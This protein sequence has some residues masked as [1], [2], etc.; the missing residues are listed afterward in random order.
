ML[1][2]IKAIPSNNPSRFFNPEDKALRGFTGCFLT[3]NLFP[4]FPLFSAPVVAAFA[5]RCIAPSVVVYWLSPRFLLYFPLFPAAAVRRFSSFSL[6]SPSF[7]SPLRL[8]R[9]F[10]ILL[11][12]FQYPALFFHV[13]PSFPHRLLLPSL[14][15]ALPLPS[16]YIGCH[17][18]FFFI[19]LCSPPRLS[20]CG[21]SVFFH[22]SFLFSVSYAL[23][24]TFLL[25]FRAG[26]CCLRF[27]MHYPFISAVRRFF[28][29]FFLFPFLLFPAA[30]VPCFFHPS[31]F[32]FSIL[33]SFSMFSPLFR[34]G[35]F[36]AF[37]LFQAEDENM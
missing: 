23:S 22:P 6:Y 27:S 36:C 12:Y 2:S 18:V 35:C 32:I 37:F 25:I 26:C 5:F 3:L 24:L 19:F 20:G 33:L 30:V 1:D 15:D 9:V 31:F 11:F 29:I 34:T 14:F 4:C 28:F 13:F 10:F 8:F 7:Y 17:L 16:L 21:C